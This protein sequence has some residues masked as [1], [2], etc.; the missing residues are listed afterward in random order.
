MN[1]LAQ[2]WFV[3]LGVGLGIF[4]FA[5]LMSDRIVNWL[6]EKSLGSRTYV[7]EKFEL[8]FIENNEKKITIT[9]LLLSFGLGFLV[10]LLVWPNLGT[11]IFLGGIVTL[12]GW[13]IPKYMVDFLYQKRCKLFVAQ[14]VDGLT[15]ISNGLRSGLSMTQSLERVTENIGNPMKQELEFVL[16][17]IRI[18]LSLEE[19]LENMAERIPEQDVEM[20]VMSVS[21]LGQTGADMSTTF[22]TI[23]DTIRERQKILQKIDAMTAQGKTQGVIMALVPVAL[24]GLFAVMDPAYIRPLYTTF[25]G[26]IFMFAMIA[27]VAIGGIMMRKVVTIKV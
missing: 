13:Q 10:F 23:T 4:G 22:V 21:I 14:M 7:L 20:F 19:A 9:M 24:F 17:Q 16:S 3:L 6:H 15:I 1:L 5:M 18:G 8:M 26:Y 25:L 2:D 11:G 27:L 12:V